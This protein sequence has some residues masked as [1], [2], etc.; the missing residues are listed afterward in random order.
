M[1]VCDIP[2]VGN[3]CNV[4]TDTAAGTLSTVLDGFADA[5]GGVA[6]VLFE[7]MWSVFEATTVVDVTT[8]RFTRV[9]NLLFG[10]A[11]FIMV[12]F[13][14]I[15]VIS[16]MIRREPAALARA[17]LGLAKSIL[18]SFIVLALVATAL[19]ITDQLTLALVSATGT[20]MEELGAHVIAL[21]ATLG[22]SLTVAPGV[23]TM[24]TLFVTSLAVGAAFIIWMSLLVRKAL[25]LVAIVF[26][27]IAMAGLTWD[28]T[29]GW[30]SKWA[31]FVL[32]LIVSKLVIVV[33]FLLATSQ[34]TA[35]ITTDLRSLSDP[36]SGV[37]LMLVAG[38]APYLTYKAISFMGVDFYHAMSTEQEAKHALNRPLPTPSGLSRA[39]P[40][41]I[42]RGSGSSAPPPTGGSGGGTAGE[43]GPSGAS[44]APGA[45]GTAGSSGTA[46]ASASGG[47]GAA[48]GAAASGAGAALAGGALVAKATWD[49]GQ[50][51]GRTV[52]GAS[53]QQHDVANEPRH[54]GTR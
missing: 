18:G 46:G 40:P 31:T 12:T 4:A 23:G 45:A 34:E 22:V 16:A 50:R 53:E 43:P 8:G 35:P 15:Q 33:F 9:Y 11:V 5:M 41:S 25:L 13:F 7:S 49:A 47:G 44:G 14:L 29:R 27:P 39:T 30:V 1:G 24:L 17:A 54:G 32:A 10:I 51:T 3:L 48:T 38:F 52:A 2:L 28:S 37:V 20:T 42:L 19:A 21:G 26:A 36:I 6:A